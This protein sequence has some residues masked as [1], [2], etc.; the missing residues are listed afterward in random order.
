[1]VSA[2]HGKGDANMNGTSRR[3]PGTYLFWG[4]ILGVGLTSLLDSAGVLTRESLFPEVF[5]L[6]VTVLGI[7]RLYK[8]NARRALEAELMR[9]I[10]SSVHEVATAAVEELVHLD[11]FHQDTSTLKGEFLPK[12]QWSGVSLMWANLEG[13]KLWLAHLENAMLWGV[14]LKDASL[15]AADLQGTSLWYANLQ[16]ADLRATLLEGA[17]LFEVNLQGAD[18]EEAQFGPDTILPDNTPWTPSTDLTRFTDPNHPN[19]WRSINPQSPAYHGD[20]SDGR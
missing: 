3:G 16:N 10:R 12:M 20:R 19:F 18:L 5:G 9:R 11:Y 1:M 6:T 17:S 15:W 2:I 4:F 7:D 13:V 14:N 8:R